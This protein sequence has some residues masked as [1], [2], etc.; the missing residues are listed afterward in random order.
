M[1]NTPLKEELEKALGML[2]KRKASGS[3]GILPKMVKAVCYE[4]KFFASLLDLVHEVW[5][6][7]PKGLG[8][9]CTTSNPQ[10]RRSQ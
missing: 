5:R 6:E 2:K 1:A 10:T 7:S 4:D 8:S 9:C 3:S